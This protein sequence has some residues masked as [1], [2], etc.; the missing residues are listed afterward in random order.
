MRMRALSTGI[1]GLV[2]AV[3]SCGATDAGRSAAYPIV[4][5]AAMPDVS[6][7]PLLSLA[8]VCILV[9]YAGAKVSERLRRSE[10][11]M[12]LRNVLSG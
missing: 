2:A 3:T 10:Q 9:V 5:H 8:A 6:L 12:L 1:R 11:R 4:A 7:A